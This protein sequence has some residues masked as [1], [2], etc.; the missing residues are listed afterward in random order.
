MHLD[1]SIPH[2][3]VGLNSEKKKKKKVKASDKNNMTKTKTIGEK[4]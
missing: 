3:T 1:K 2:G 4:I